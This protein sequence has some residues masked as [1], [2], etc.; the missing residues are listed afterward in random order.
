[1]SFRHENQC[2]HPDPQPGTF[3]EGRRAVRLGA[4]IDSYYLDGVEYGQTLGLPS[5]TVGCF[6][7]GVMLI[8]LERVRAEGLFS[9]AID[10]VAPQIRLP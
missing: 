6:N 1:M 9:S 3:A 4:V 7:A 5:S 2:D 10:L 8:D